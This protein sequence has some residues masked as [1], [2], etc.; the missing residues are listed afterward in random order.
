MLAIIVV[1]LKAVIFGII[2]RK[3][4]QT[5][6]ENLT[7]TGKNILKPAKYVLWTGI[8]TSIFCTFCIIIAQGNPTFT[9]WVAILFLL[10]DVLG[11]YL[12]ISYFLA[13]HS[14]DEKGFHYRT[15]FGKIIFVYWHDLQDID[16]SGSLQM[17]ILTDKLG[18]KFYIST[19]VTGLRSFAQLLVK[20]AINIQDKDTHL[21]L[22]L[23]RNIADFDS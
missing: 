6:V 11:L 1:I 21:I 13:C 9:L 10:F 20:N 16:Y 12:I 8:F 2:Y 18:R 4:S 17:F 22:G 7:K 5:N 3:I 23:M 14:F 19:A 15:T